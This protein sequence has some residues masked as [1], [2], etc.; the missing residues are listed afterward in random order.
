MDI[1]GGTKKIKE[2]LQGK[3]E[4]AF[5]DARSRFYFS[6]F[7]LI[8]LFFAYTMFFLIPAFSEISSLRRTARSL[9]GEIDLIEERAERLDDS[10]ERLKEMKSVLQGYSEALP[11]EKELPI[12]LEELSNTAD[13]SGVRIV[14]IRPLTSQQDKKELQMAEYYRPFPVEISAKCGFHQLG[15][16]VNALETGRR[17]ITIGD[18]KIKHDRSSP[19]EH[20]VYIALETYVSVGE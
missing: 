18:L 11:P 16:F 3:I 10:V 12:F 8:F 5:G 13:I 15:E 1:S 6:V 2:M 19:R 7:C 14:S 17:A 20:D 9:S 4:E